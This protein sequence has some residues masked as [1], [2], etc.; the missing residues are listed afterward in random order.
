MRHIRTAGSSR[1][2]GR[3]GLAAVLMLLLVATG[4]TAGGTDPSPLPRRPA[5]STSPEPSESASPRTFPT[6]RTSGPRA[7]PQQRTGPLK[8]DRDGQTIENVTIEGRLTI[9]HDDVTVRD[10][11]V[12]G[13]GTYMIYV[14]KTSAGSCPRDVRLEFVEIDGSQAP[15]DSI[16]FYSPECGFTL[17]HA[18]IHDVGRG[19]R[20]ANDALIENSYIMLTRT[21]E[22]AHRSGV[23]THGGRNIVLHNNVIIC[24]NVGCSAAITMYGDAAP[25]D[26]VLVEHNLIAS[27]GSYCAYGG[28]LDSKSFPRGSDVHFIDNEFST[29]Y[30]P[31]CG[32][33]GPVA[34]F[35]A[36]D[37][38]NVWRG[39][40]W[41]ESGEQIPESS[42]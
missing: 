10:V 23:S 26:G 13:T 14:D 9:S 36:G 5:E 3:R 19:I 12:R 31:T 40:I 8:T 33:Y 7:D 28:S 41:H 38:G 25:I 15:A 37:R 21:W 20:I 6:D 17:D 34:G 35:E 24:E 30:F 29:R 22:G 32:R 4:C 2:A 11:R 42:L 1:R 39:N 18:L 16:P 27:T